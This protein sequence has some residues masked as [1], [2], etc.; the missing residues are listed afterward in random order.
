MASVPPRPRRAFSKAARAFS[1]SRR[2]RATL[3]ERLD[4]PQPTEG[5]RAI[6]TDL[7]DV[8]GAAYKASKRDEEGY[9]S[10]PEMGQRAKAVS[11]FAVRNYGYT[12]LSDLIRA[13]PNFDVKTGEDGRLWCAGYVSTVRCG[14]AATSRINLRSC[15]LYQGTIITHGRL[16]TP[17]QRIRIAALGSGAT[18]SHRPIKTSE[19]FVP[20]RCRGACQQAAAVLLRD[21]GPQALSDFDEFPAPLY[22]IDDNRQDPLFQLSLDRFRRPHT[23]PSRRPMVRHLEALCSTTATALPHDQCPMAVAI[24]DGRPVRSVEAC[25]RTARRGADPISSLP[26]TSDR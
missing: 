1:I 10:L 8:L 2:L 24:R 21:L 3:N 14:K 20:W 25:R 5:Q 11:S 17:H 13:V 4:R 12:R 15:W 22:A 19:A 26:H 16:L 6:D 7:L 23:D 9:A 18:H